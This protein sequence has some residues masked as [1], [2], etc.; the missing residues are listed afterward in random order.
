MSNVELSAIA[1]GGVERA[2][3]QFERAATTVSG[4][5]SPDGPAVD[6]VDLS[7][8]AVSMLAAHND[9]TAN[10][11]VLKVADDMQRHAIDMLA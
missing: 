4:A 3:A 11:N 7:S 2:S 8:A 9:F 10:L 1:L 6:T 5:A